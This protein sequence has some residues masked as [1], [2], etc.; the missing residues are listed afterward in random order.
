MRGEVIVDDLVRRGGRGI[1]E[2]QDRRVEIIA[3]VEAEIVGGLVEADRVFGAIGAGA[4]DDAGQAVLALHAGEIVLLRLHAEQER[5]G[6]VRDDFFPLVARGRLHRGF[7]H[8]EVDGAVQ[9]GRDV[10]LAI[11]VD[12]GIFIVGLA[13]R[14]G[15][16]RRV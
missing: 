9:I 16:Q 7:H 4:H 15:A 5:A 12:H 8:L 11:P 2:A 13:R 1:V 10:E 6:A 14:N 3:A